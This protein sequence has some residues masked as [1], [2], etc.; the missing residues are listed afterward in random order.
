MFEIK[1]GLLLLC[2]AYAGFR[3]WGGGLSA[4]NILLAILV[5]VAVVYTILQKMGVIDALD[6]MRQQEEKKQQKKK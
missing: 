1:D 3:I 6:K 4:V 2:V 5:A